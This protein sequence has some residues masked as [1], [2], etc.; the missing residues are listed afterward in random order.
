[1]DQ[2][3][4]QRHKQ[5]QVVPATCYVPGEMLPFNS[6]AWSLLNGCEG[7]EFKFLPQKQTQVMAAVLMMSLPILILILSSV[8][9]KID[10]SY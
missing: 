8:K 9:A 1:M 10:D 6:T 4:L 5:A 7:V 2:D 3:D